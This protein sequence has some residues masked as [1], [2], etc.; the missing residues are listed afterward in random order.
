MPLR[1]SIWFHTL[2]ERY[3]KTHLKPANQPIDKAFHSKIIIEREREKSVFRQAKILDQKI[4][5]DK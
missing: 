5:E 1:K 2:S 3:P 4:R